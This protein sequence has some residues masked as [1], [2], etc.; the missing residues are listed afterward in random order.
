MVIDPCFH[1]ALGTNVAQTLADDL[2]TAV[3]GKIA[4]TP[5]IRVRMYELPYVKGAG[6]T[7]EKLLNKGTSPASTL[8]REQALCL[9]FYAGQNKPRQRGRVYLPIVWLGSGY[10]GVRP[11]TPMMTAALS[12]RTIF[13]NLGGV[14]IDWVVW[15]EKDAQSRPVTDVWVDDEHDTVRSRGLRPTSRLTA[16]T[17]EAG[18]PNLVRL[19]SD[20]P[21][22]T[23]DELA[24]VQPADEAA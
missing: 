24:A 2:A 5:Q 4:G 22:F 1:D 8:P 23:A 6:H 15:S 20:L 13:E 17:S 19:S 11:T 14:N 7:A 10:G 3:N 16:T 12:W 18:A 21:P 9:S